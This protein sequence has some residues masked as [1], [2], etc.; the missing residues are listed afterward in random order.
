MTAEPLTAELSSAVR[1]W[2]ARDPDPATR[3][4]LGALVASAEAGDGA[5][6]ADLASRF[7]GPLM[8][9]TAGLRA[10]VGAGE[11]RMNRAVVI[12]ATA[13]LAAFL[14]ERVGERP[15][16]VVGC[17]ARHG[18]ADFAA[19]AA[20]VLAAA[21]CRA[22]RLPAQ[23]PTPVVAYA[24]R[25]L[26]ADAGVMVTASHNPPAD[27]GY[28]V[29]LGARAVDSDDE[30][31]VQIVPPD[32]A[33]IAERIAAAPPANEV[34]RADADVEWAGDSL[35]HGYI[36]RAAALRG[37]DEPSDVRI[38]LTPM[39][40]VGGETAVRVLEHAGFPNVTVVPEQARPDP[41]FP[42][43]VFPNPEEPGAMDLAL[44]LGS[45]DNADV[46]IALDPD[47]DRCAIA[48]PGVSDTGNTTW[49]R[50]TG[51]E[52]GAL[53]GEHAASDPDRSGDTLA[54]SIV[55]GRLLGRIAEHHGLKF[56]QTLTGFK[57]IARTPGL[58][59]G[60]EEAIGY[61]TDPLAVRDKDGITTAVRVASYVHRLKHSNA[62][63][64]GELDRLARLHG[65]YA[66]A[67]L[68]FRVADLELIP[69]GMQRLRENP[70][71][72]LAGSPVVEYT[73][74]SKGGPEMLPTEGV[75]LRT[76]ADDRVIVRPSGT[77][78]KLKCYLE[79]VLPVDGN[80]EIPR[81]S[82]EVRLERIS[83]EIRRA[84]G[85]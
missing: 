65:L 28:K 56:R 68:T 15:V 74:L 49:R 22:I 31:G 59:F 2:I 42:T 30:R 3:A 60:Y 17:D 69:Q 33:H 73:D 4:E 79:V 35:L 82:A 20:A 23:L 19:D 72:D 36:S 21:G 45:E 48:I 63:V 18:S 9:G 71:A 11:S 8:F 55:S 78:P 76:E 70:P 10:A 81:R 80:A 52:L 32:D 6:V 39:H 47:A 51:D 62:T 34:P 38:V 53:L 1:N 66:T 54:C 44:A 64:Q 83:D 40:G 84:V 12:R 26:G 50:L 58:R 24:V 14:T 41:E 25:E 67:P 5:A 27:N 7:S 16:V 43:V 13:G 85:F 75:L 37:T 61:C 57:W 29:Y 77:E 46:V